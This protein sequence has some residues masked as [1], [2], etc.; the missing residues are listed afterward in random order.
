MLWPMRFNGP[1]RRAGP[2]ARSGVALAF[3]GILHVAVNR[4][5]GRFLDRDWA[6]GGLDTENDRVAGLLSND[7]KQPELHERG[8]PVHELSGIGE[9]PE[10]GRFSASLLE[11][12]QAFLAGADDLREY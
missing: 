11:R 9:I 1:R 5:T 12:C 10:S 3:T 2:P 4:C 6:R 7:L 8:I